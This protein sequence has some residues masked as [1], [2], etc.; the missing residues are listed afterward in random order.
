MSPLAVTFICIGVILVA[1]FVAY[2]CQKRKDN[3]N[4]RSR[5]RE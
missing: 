1:L 3:R 2:F 4:S 5:E